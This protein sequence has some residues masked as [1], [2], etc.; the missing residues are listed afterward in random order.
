MAQKTIIV[1][2]IIAHIEYINSISK[3]TGPIISTTKL[4]IFNIF[5]TSYQ[6]LNKANNFIT[7][8]KIKTPNIAPIP[9]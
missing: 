6:N 5:F 4:Y 9:Y 7:K 1:N 3:G 8:T 2:N